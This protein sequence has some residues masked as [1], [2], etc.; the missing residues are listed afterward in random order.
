MH[1]RCSLGA[2]TTVCSRIS[3]WDFSVE[4]VR[5]FNMLRAADH[6]TYICVPNDEYFSAEATVQWGHWGAE[7]GKWRKVLAD[8]LTPSDGH[9]RWPRV[10]K[11]APKGAADE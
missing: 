6:E 10:Q 9:N 5:E 4:D 11:A 8:G 1:S 7:N 2:M 3:L